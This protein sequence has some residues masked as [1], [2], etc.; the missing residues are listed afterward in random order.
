MHTII[1]FLELGYCGS[2]VHLPAKPVASCGFCVYINIARGV[3][4][5]KDSADIVTRNYKPWGIDY[6]DRAIISHVYRFQS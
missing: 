6:R 4:Y 2:D 1:R 3:L 5:E